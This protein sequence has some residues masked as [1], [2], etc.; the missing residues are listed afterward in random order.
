MKW[1]D[2]FNYD[3]GVLYWKIKPCKNLPVGFRAGYYKSRWS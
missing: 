1:S 3:N 2:I